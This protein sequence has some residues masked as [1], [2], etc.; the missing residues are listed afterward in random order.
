MLNR[1]HFD[2]QRICRKICIV[3]IREISKLYSAFVCVNH[4]QTCDM[5]VW[6]R[7]RMNISRWHACTL[8]NHDCKRIIKYFNAPNDHMCTR[9]TWLGAWWIYAPILNIL[10]FFMVYFHSITVGVVRLSA[11]KLRLRWY[12]IAL[13]LQQVNIS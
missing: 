8:R 13:Q 10:F 9:M 6:W 7:V 5:T 12:I 3:F 1:Y 11:S 2:I 4:C